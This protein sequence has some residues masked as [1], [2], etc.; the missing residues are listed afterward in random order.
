MH[1][2][3]QKRF[4]VPGASYFITALTYKRYP[5][6]EEDVLCDL[7]ADSL[8][9]CGIV[10]GFYLHGFSIMPDH[11]HL[12]IQPAHLKESDDSN[13][14]FLSDRRF[15]DGVN[16]SGIMG[17]LKRNFSRD[18]DSVMG[19]GDERF[20][21]SGGSTL[22][23][24]GDT[25]GVR[26]APDGGGI[27][28]ARIRIHAFGGESVSF[29]AH[30]TNLE[31][32]R[33]AFIMKHGHSSPHPPFRWHKSYHDHVIRDEWDFANHLRYIAR[34]REKHGAPGHVWVCT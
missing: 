32:H 19:Y 3:S 26:G 25:P 5:Y 29:E 7:F 8:M 10:K 30:I 11:V 4:Y 18:C 22:P 2:N 1:R 20:L 24:E 16:I 34:Q 23:C 31:K 27:S 33:S 21:R 17:S 13:R 28:K 15:L 6:F 9:F 12:L 14:R